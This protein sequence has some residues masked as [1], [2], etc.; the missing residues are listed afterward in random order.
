MSK[1]KMHDMGYEEEWKKAARLR[2]EKSTSDPMAPNTGGGPVYSSDDGDGDE[3]EPEEDHPE[4]HMSDIPQKLHEAM[5]AT[6][7]D[8]H[9]VH[10][11]H[12]IIKG[13]VTEHGVKNHE[14]TGS[15]HHAT[16]KIHSMG[17]HPDSKEVKSR[18]D[19]QTDTGGDAMDSYVTSLTKK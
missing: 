4:L 7:K 6:P 9:G 10:H 17:M 15:R 5:T 11:V 14:I 12:M 2:K 1:E 13:H 8:E 16:I 3:D 19:D 18:D